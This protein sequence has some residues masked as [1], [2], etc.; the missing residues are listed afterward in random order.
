MSN[1]QRVAWYGAFFVAGIIAVVAA[2]LGY[3]DETVE[4]FGIALAAISL[5]G[6]GKAA[7]YAKD[8]AYAKKVDVSNSDERF[9]YLANKSAQSAFQI[10]VV[11]LA[12][13]SVAIRP[14]GYNETASVLSC[15]MGGEVAVYWVSYLVASRRY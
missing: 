6:L 11:A 2:A 7:R 10:S 4:C 15:V 5:L 3:V 8:P 1:T 12:V 13:L 9:A 14:F